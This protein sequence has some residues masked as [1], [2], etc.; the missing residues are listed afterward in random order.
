MLPSH[1]VVPGTQLPVQLVPTHAEATHATGVPHVP[2]LHVCRPLPEHSVIPSVQLPLQAPAVHMFVGQ[3]CV[4]P[5]CPLEPHVS[6]PVPSHR[7]LFGVHAPAQ[8]LLWQTNWQDMALPH[9]PFAPQVSSAVALVHCVAPGAHTPVHA[10]FEHAWF[11]HGDPTVC[12]V[13]VG[14]HSCGC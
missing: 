12:H 10:P 11:A 3:L 13:P 9:I 4:A 14:P 1:S 6:T 5:H 8:A 7:V 2:P